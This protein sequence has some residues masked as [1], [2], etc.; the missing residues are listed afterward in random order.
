MLLPFIG[1]RWAELSSW[2]WVDAV[3][4][5]SSGTARAPRRSQGA[6]WWRVLRSEYTDIPILCFKTLRRFRAWLALTTT[7]AE[8]PGAWLPVIARRG[9]ARVGAGLRKRLQLQPRVQFR[10]AD[11]A[12]QL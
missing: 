3:T 9:S 12:K 8:R 10:F 11:S 4:C 1:N 5:S 6:K 7:S 2:A